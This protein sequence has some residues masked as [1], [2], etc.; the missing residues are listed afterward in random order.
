[1]RIIRNLRIYVLSRVVPLDY[2]TN[3]CMYMYMYIPIEHL[4]TYNVC[5]N[6]SRRIVES[7]ERE[8]ICF[9][10]IT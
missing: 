8:R 6:T 2:R 10:V 1:M 7:R 5:V 3:M 4:N 9:D